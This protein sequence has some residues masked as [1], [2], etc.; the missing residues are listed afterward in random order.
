MVVGAT[1]TD[2][3]GNGSTVKVTLLGVVLIQLGVPDDA[4]LTILITVLAVKVLLMVAVPEAFKVMVWL[5]PPL[6]L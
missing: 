6:M 2:A 1:L 3:V 5:A 4:T